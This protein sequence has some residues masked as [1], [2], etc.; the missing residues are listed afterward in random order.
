M[1]SLFLFLFFNESKS[2][3]KPICLCEEA[4]CFGSNPNQPSNFKYMKYGSDEKDQWEYINYLIPDQK[5]TD[6]PIK[7]TQRS[8]YLQKIETGQ[9]SEQ[10]E[11]DEFSGNY[12]SRDV[13]NLKMPSSGHSIEFNTESHSQINDVLGTP[14]SNSKKNT[15]QIEYA[16]C[17][18]DSSKNEISKETGHS[19]KLNPTNQIREHNLPLSEAV[20]EYKLT[21]DKD[22]SQNSNEQGNSRISQIDNPQNNNL[23]SYFFEISS[24]MDSK[25][26]HVNKIINTA[27]V[28]PEMGIKNIKPKNLEN[29]LL[30][31]EAVYVN[32]IWRYPIRVVIVKNFLGVSQFSTLRHKNINNELL[33]ND[34]Y[35]LNLEFLVENDFQESNKDEVLCPTVK[36]SFKDLY[37]IGS[38]I[39]P[40]FFGL[41]LDKIIIFKLLRYDIGNP[42]YVIYSLDSNLGNTITNKIFGHTNMEIRI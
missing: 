34:P 8:T 24:T 32:G 7:T 21:P 37:G 14:L 4:C 9:H 12:A 41:H 27:F 36:I 42:I 29:S 26:S 25:G 22:E 38:K 28:N 6:L 31:I 1:S 39:N 17:S 18:F 40:V 16:D 19:T 2:A 10:V 23:K 13:V 30:Y 20:S 15:G 5:N 3:S 11:K 33:H 35:I